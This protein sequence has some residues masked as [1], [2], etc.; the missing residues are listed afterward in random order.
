[1]RVNTLDD[2]AIKFQ[3]KAQHAM[4]RRML[5]PEVYVEGADVGFRPGITA[6]NSE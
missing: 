2:L 1:M 3:H 4:R 5:R 6:V